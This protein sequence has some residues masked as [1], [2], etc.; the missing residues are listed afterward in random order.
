MEQQVS[1][2]RNIYGKPLVPCSFDPMT[3][4]FRTGCCETDE[5]DRGSHTV[6]VQLTAEFLAFSKQMGNDLIT[7]RPEWGFPGLKPGDR[8]CVCAPR[9][10]EAYDAGFA[11]PVILEACHHGALQ[12]VTLA[13]L[14]EHAV[15]LN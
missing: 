5:K 11:A 6:C 4:F 12:Y 8:W 10:K 15:K 14:E 1:Q 9:W 3:G 13:Q 7:P 2:Q